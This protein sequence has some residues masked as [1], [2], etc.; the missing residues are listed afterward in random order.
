VLD[1]RETEFID[2]AG[3]QILLGIQRRLSQASRK[4]TV[5][6]D[7]GPVRRVIELTRLAEV[8]GLTRGDETA[9]A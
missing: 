7:D 2:S 8:L 3:L 1:L 5:I 9:D 4:L 6:C